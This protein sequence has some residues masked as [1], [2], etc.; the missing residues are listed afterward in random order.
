MS[1]VIIPDQS[2]HVWPR[3]AASLTRMFTTEKKNTNVYEHV[4]Q[5]SDEAESMNK[6]FQEEK[7]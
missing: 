4:K 6:S 7:W 1:N 3:L 2:G 5:K